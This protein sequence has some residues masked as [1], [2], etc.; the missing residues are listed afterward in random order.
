MTI[1]ELNLDN[2]KVGDE[3]TTLGFKGEPKKYGSIRIVTG[4]DEKVKRWKLAKPENPEKNVDSFP[5]DGKGYFFMQKRDTEPGF[6]YSANPEHI[7][8]AKAY[9]E[10]KK[11]ER[12]KR[13]QEQKRRMNLALPIGDLLKGEW[14]DHNGYWDNSNEIAETLTNRLTDEQIITLKGWLGV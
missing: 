8:A 12:E 2:L 5:V 10:R 9:H 1:Q 6:Y 14:E 4:W 7:K 13:E 3:V 11:I